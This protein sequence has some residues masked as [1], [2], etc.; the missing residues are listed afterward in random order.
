M[1][2]LNS[3]I[4][5]LRDNGNFIF[6]VVF[7]HLYH[8]VSVFLLFAT[9]LSFNKASFCFYHLHVA[10][11]VY[12]GGSGTGSLPSLVVV[13]WWQGCVWL[14]KCHACSLERD[15]LS[16]NERH[17][18]D[19]ITDWRWLCSRIWKTCKNIWVRKV[20]LPLEA[21]IQVFPLITRIKKEI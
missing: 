14:G 2:A 8:T 18:K 21:K 20:F 7:S 10:D 5:A 13:R 15:T 9:P 16:L 4:A 11:I 17:T 19:Q 3:F 12:F 6:L 1:Q